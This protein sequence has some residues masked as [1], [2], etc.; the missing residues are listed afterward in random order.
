MNGIYCDIGGLEGEMM[1]ESCVERS[2]SSSELIDQESMKI[3]VEVTSSGVSVVMLRK[4]E[5]LRP[6]RAAAVTPR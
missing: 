1:W 6:L 2:E 5:E 3:W 4:I